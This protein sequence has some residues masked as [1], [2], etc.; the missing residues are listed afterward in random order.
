MDNLKKRNLAR[1]VL[2]GIALLGILFGLFVFCIS[3]AMFFESMEPDFVLLCG[4]LVIS[5][6]VL[7]IGVYLIYISYLML[8][9]ITYAAIKP[10]GTLLAFA[11]YFW[12]SPLT[13]SLARML[14]E[15]GLRFIGATVGIASLPLAIAVYYVF[16]RILARL[17]KVGSEPGINSKNDPPKAV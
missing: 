15:K 8:R 10:L 1:F 14:E 17:S 11:F 3:V 7:A 9:G 2:Q 16:T 12:S 6:L 5:I 4:G 13:W